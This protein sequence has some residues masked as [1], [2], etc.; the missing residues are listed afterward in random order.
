MIQTSTDLSQ[1]VSFGLKS[2]KMKL[3]IDNLI[4]LV[5]SNLRFVSELSIVI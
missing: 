5:F 2:D 1:G 4:D 3:I